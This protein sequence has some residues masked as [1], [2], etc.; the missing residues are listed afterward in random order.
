ME[1][2]YIYIGQVQIQNISVSKLNRS[3]QRRFDLTILTISLES[4]PN[5]RQEQKKK[6]NSIYLY[7]INNQGINIIFYSISACPIQIYYPDGR[8]KEKGIDRY[9]PNN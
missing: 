6:K 7:S 1:R 8:E 5:T 4:R 2:G 9:L 3:L